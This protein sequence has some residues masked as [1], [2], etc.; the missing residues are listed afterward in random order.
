MIYSI[1][2]HFLPN[3]SAN[4][5]VGLSLTPSGRK[6]IFYKKNNWLHYVFNVLLDIGT[7]FAFNHR[8]I[9]KIKQI[10]YDKP[11]INKEE[12]KWVPRQRGNQ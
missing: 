1:C 11:S 6:K 4:Y 9:G 5:S 7:S 12:I 10:H 8:N 2:K 3:I